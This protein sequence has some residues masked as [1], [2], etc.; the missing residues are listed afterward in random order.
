MTISFEDQLREDLH[1]AAGNASFEAFPGLEPSS[2]IR[3]GRRAVQRRRLRYAAGLA[4]LATVA[5]VAGL[6][7]GDGDPSRAVTP[8]AGTTSRPSVSTT[9]VPTLNPGRFGAPVELRPGGK[10][11]DD[12]SARTVFSVHGVATGGRRMVALFDQTEGFGRAV[13]A[14]SLDDPGATADIVFVNGPMAVLV[15][16]E[17]LSTLRLGADGPSLQ[18]VASAPVAGT[19]QWL[20]VGSL[21]TS[22]LTPWVDLYWTTDSGATGHTG[23]PTA[24]IAAVPGKAGPAGWAGFPVR[25]TSRPSV[26]DPLVEVERSDDPSVPMLHAG[27]LSP[28]G[29]D[30]VFFRGDGAG[31]AM[32]YGLTRA[33]PVSVLPHGDTASRFADGWT[34]ATVELGGGWWASAIRLS[35][36]D[37][38]SPDPV[39]SISWTD[40]A[41]TTHDVD[42]P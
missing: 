14:L 28:A 30:Q 40:A 32:I 35:G 7:L 9:V 39:P 4:A 25:F 19:S 26:G 34:F 21:P 27:V 22:W 33:R 41:G 18:Q 2:V 20:T 12:P 13:S 37:D 8:P 10:D 15:T 29:K 17:P 16:S 38:S 6:A 42:L 24:A 3:L 11:G 23:A 36:M 1:S 5:V 31:F